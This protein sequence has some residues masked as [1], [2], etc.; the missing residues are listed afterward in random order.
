MFVTTKSADFR[1][2]LPSLNM[3]TEGQVCE[4]LITV[5]E[6]CIKCELALNLCVFALAICVYIINAGLCVHACVVWGGGGVRVGV[7]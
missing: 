5:S 2:C 6:Y 7:Y 1:G 4:S 3:L